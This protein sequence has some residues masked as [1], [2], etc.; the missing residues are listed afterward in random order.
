MLD[1]SGTMVHSWGMGDLLKETLEL[2]KTTPLTTEEVCK[3]AK[4]KQRWYYDLLSGRFKDPGV[5]KI[6]RLN[7]ALK[8]AHGHA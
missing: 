7:A 6:T 3:R 5:N 4:V 1:G 8:A 2:A